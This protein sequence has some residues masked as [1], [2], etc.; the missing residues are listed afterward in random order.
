MRALNL[1]I[2]GFNIFGKFHIFIHDFDAIVIFI[3]KGSLLDIVDHA[4]L[5]SFLWSFQVR[6]AYGKGVIINV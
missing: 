2:Y 5:E 1:Q 6:A 3:L 4:F